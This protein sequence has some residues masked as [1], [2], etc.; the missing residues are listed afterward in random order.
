MGTSEQLL[1]LYLR[2]R[3]PDTG[4]CTVARVLACDAL[5]C[6]TTGLQDGDDQRPWTGAAAR[7]AEPIIFVLCGLLL[8]CLLA[9]LVRERL[10]ATAP[11]PPFL[12]H[13]HMRL[14]QLCLLALRGTLSLAF[15]VYPCLSCVHTCGLINFLR[16][17]SVCAGE[18]RGFA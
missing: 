1:N 8:C 14:A 3:N 2:R 16:V 9:R 10:R 17:H 6:P 7:D 5:G 11:P 13:T 15:A 18:K 4:Q 12:T